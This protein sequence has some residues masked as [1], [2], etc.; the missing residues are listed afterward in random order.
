[1]IFSWRLSPLQK[2]I[3]LAFCT[4]QLCRIWGIK[5][6]IKSTTIVWDR[7]ACS[8]LEATRHTTQF[9]I[10]FLF[11][12]FTSPED[13]GDVFLWNIRWLLTDYISL[14][15][16]R[17]DCLPLSLCQYESFVKYELLL[18]LLLLLL[19]VRTLYNRASNSETD[20]ADPNRE[21]VWNN[22]VT[23]LHIAPVWNSHINF[24][25]I[26]ITYSIYTLKILEYLLLSRINTS[27]TPWSESASE[28]Y[29]PSDSSLLAKWLPTFADRGCHVVRVTN[30]HG[31]ILDF[32]DRSRYFSIK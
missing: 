16:R 23:V 21:L 9:Y 6:T 27:K 22:A 3:I 26:Y 15:H 1:M 30:P 29:R 24:K 10:G 8:P 32:L 31:R 19:L 13:G 18:L 4:I 25:P 20:S 2:L 17:K 28:L 7:A 14:N 11:G 5:S 12:V